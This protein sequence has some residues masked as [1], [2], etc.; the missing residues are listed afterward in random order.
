MLGEN[1][2]VFELNRLE[3][4]HHLICLKCKKIIDIGECPL[5]KFEKDIENETEFDIVGHNYEI[6]GYCPECKKKKQD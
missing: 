4:N 1:K 5:S 6:Y 2:S 3:H